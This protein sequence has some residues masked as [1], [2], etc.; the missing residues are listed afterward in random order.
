MIPQWGI[1]GAAI[2]T[3]IALLIFN[4]GR[5][6]FIWAIYKIHPFTRNQFTVIGLSVIALVAGHFTQGLINNKWI[7]FLFE[8]TL[9]VVL[10]F[11]PIYLLSLETETVNYIKKGIAFIRFKF[12]GN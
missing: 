1:V 6:I 12:R 8:S 5:L 2:S 3:T 9:V 7:Q 11:V 4:F 10:F